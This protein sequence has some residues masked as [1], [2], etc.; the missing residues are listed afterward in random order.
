MGGESLVNNEGEKMIRPDSKVEFDGKGS[1]VA[2]CYDGKER[3]FKI[4]K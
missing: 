2:T 1:F 3:N 4:K